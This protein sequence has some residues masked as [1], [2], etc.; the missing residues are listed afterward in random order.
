MMILMVACPEEKAED[1]PN[2]IQHG[3]AG[4]PRLTLRTIIVSLLKATT[5]SQSAASCARPRHYSQQHQHLRITQGRK[6]FHC[7][8]NQLVKHTLQKVVYIKVEL[9]SGK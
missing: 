8:N 1:L 4:Q 6:P 2:E 3:R 9:N 5:A 7:I